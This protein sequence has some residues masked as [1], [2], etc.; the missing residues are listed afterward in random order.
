MI[1]KIIIPLIVFC[2]FQSYGQTVQDSAVLKYL[3]LTNE[4]NREWIDSL[5]VLP[6]EQRIGRVIQRVTMDTN[7]FIRYDYCANLNLKRDYSFEEKFKVEACCRPVYAL[8]GLPFFLDN[9]FS[10]YSMLRINV[11]KLLKVLTSANVRDIQVLP[12]ELETALYG[13]NGSNGVVLINAPGRKNRR[14]IKRIRR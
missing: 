12:R 13:L 8:N 4:Q 7:V 6:A 5:S 14:L 11:S 2:C 1:S 3:V 10:T 9:R